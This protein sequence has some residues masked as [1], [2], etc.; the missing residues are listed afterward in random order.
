MQSEGGGSTLWSAGPFVY[1]G[2]GNVTTIGSDSYDYDRVGRLTRGFVQGKT[3][4]VAYD[5]YGN[6]T[7]LV[8]EGRDANLEVDPAT[9]RLSMAGVAYDSSGNLTNHSGIADAVYDPFNRM[10]ELTAQGV[11]QAYLYDADDNRVATLDYLAE[12]TRWTVRDRGEN[13]LADFTID[14]DEDDVVLGREYVYRGDSLLASFDG[15]DVRHYHLDHLGSTRLVT[16]SSGEMIAEYTYYP[17]GELVSATADDRLLFTG[18][19]RDFNRTDGEVPEN[20]D[21]DYMLA[22]HY[23]PRFGRFLS[24]DAL[25]GERGTPQSWNRYAYALGN[26][27]RY[28]DPDGRSEEEEPL[29]HLLKEYIAVSSVEIGMEMFVDDVSK[30]GRFLGDLTETPI[31]RGA[32]W[33]LAT[34]TIGEYAIQKSE[35]LNQRLS[36]DIGAIV[37]EVNK[38]FYDRHS[39]ELASV[40]SYI[41]TL[42]RL[43]SSDRYDL[44]NPALSSAEMRE[45]RDAIALRQRIIKEQKR[46]QKEL[47][48]L[49]RSLVYREDVD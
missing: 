43:N 27:M 16:G 10:T 3:Q 47:R 9:N 25:L 13:V 34:L 4:G 41:F 5:P 23:A 46:R 48:R 14:W 31:A 29:E 39:K 19:E 45:I 42:G 15:A 6:I 28:S 12:E 20:D 44:Q 21:L 8:T 26:P 18:H 30:V 49:L 37:N 32:H 24:M 22:R 1:D 33:G 35:N 7:S 36:E 11:N 2:A 38:A 17:F 40:E